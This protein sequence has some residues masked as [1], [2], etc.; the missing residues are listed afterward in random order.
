MA[1]FTLALLLF[2]TFITKIISWLFFVFYSVAYLYLTLY[3]D[4][5]SNLSNHGSYNRLVLVVWTGLYC[6]VIYIVYK[7]RYFILKTY[8]KYFLLL[9]AIILG[10]V[11]VIFFSLMFNCKDWDKGLKDTRIINDNS[12]SNCN[13]LKPTYCWLDTFRGFQDI[14]KFLGESCDNFRE[15]EKAELFKYLPSRYNQSLNFGFPRSSLFSF[16]HNKEAW[17]KIYPFNVFSNFIDIDHPE[18]NNKTSGYDSTPEVFLRFNET[19]NLGEIEIKVEKNETLSK[20]RKS[21][22]ESNPTMVK[23]ILYIYID[24]LSRRHFHR[25]MAK[26]KAFLE[27]HYKTNETDITAYQFLKYHNFIFFTPPN[28][29]PMFYGESMQHH[30]G[31][32]IIRKLKQLG[33]VTGDSHNQCSKELY[34]IEDSYT[35][36][37]N[38]E[39]FDHEN[40]AL[41]CD[42]NYNNPNDAYTPYHGPYSMKRRCLYGKDTFEYSIEYARQFWEAY[43]ENR[44]Y[45]IIGNIDAHEG[46]GEVIKSYDEPISDF[47]K[48]LYS[49]GELKDTAVFIGSDHGNN[50]FGLYSIYNVDDFHREKTLGTLFMMLPKDKVTSEIDNNLKANENVMVTPYDIFNTLV[51]LSGDKTHPKT[52]R[53]ESLFNAINGTQRNCSNYELDLKPLWCRCE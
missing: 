35:N 51:D 10:S 39:S 38:W 20:H 21:L 31:T 36:G 19:N 45:L 16:T 2:F 47:L 43:K 17:F 26:T 9:L 49:K 12:I 11:V 3:F 1:S 4:T 13:I 24:A 25:N 5:G 34:D 33:F 30:N 18:N 29:N 41:F 44:K 42:P 32:H 6:L 8:P 48:N 23:N 52:H 22:E 40:N 15:G 50:M 28:V 27:E 7:M 53:G 37:I 46:T 14:S